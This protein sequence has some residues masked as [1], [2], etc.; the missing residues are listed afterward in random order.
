MSRPDP[1]AEDLSPA[2]TVARPAHL[3]GDAPSRWSES[4]IDELVEI[5]GRAGIGLDREAARDWLRAVVAADATPG[6]FS[7]TFDG[8]FGGHELALIDFDPAAAARLRQ[9]GRLIATPATEGVAT[10]LAIAGSAAQGRIQ[11]FPADADYF[12]RIHV[13]APS[14]VD[15]VSR[16]AIAVR[17]TILRAMDEP[18]LRFEEVYFGHREGLTLLWSPHEF[19]AGVIERRLPNGDPVALTWLEAAADPGFVKIDWTL[20]DPSL[21]GPGKVSKAIDATW[22]TPD[23]TIE[24]LD[25]AIDADYQQVYL[26]AAAADLA[27]AVTSGLAPGSRDHYVW[28]MEREIA[29]YG[30]G[31]YGDYAKVAKRLYNLCRLTGRF[32]EAVY[33]RELFDEPAA[34]LH[35]IRLR[36]E[37]AGLL[38]ESERQALATELLALAQADRVWCE[39][40]DRNLI[41]Q[42]AEQMRAADIDPSLA[43]MADTDDA[44]RRIVS[45]SFER[46]LRSYGPISR[47]IDEI[48]RRHADLAPPH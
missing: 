19:A 38:T 47:L 34:R 7:R 1:T 31:E 21:G 14:R 29:K 11:P 28:H 30:H 3:Q 40:S 20:V 45:A 22:Q 18:G 41:C 15:A 8:E 36:I 25:G 27:A 37:L 32:A 33:V 6:E 39:D 4:V 46:G 5:A 12:E 9:I 23:G 35:Q 13:V 24:S 42:W 2:Q 26:D 17:S 43:P 16:F 10:A 48:R 44:A